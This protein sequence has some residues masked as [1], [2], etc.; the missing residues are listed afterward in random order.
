[1]N[2]PA[3]PSLAFRA[4]DHGDKVTT[5][6]VIPCY[7]S[8]STLKELISSLA[9]QIDAPRFEVVLVDNGPTPGLQELA[10]ANKALLD[11]TLVMATQGTGTAYARNVGIRSASGSNIL[12]VDHDD[13]VE[14]QYVRAMTNALKEH[15]FVCAKLDLKALN[16]P[17]FLNPP[18]DQYQQTEVTRFPGGN[19]VPFASGGT[20]GFRREV[21]VKV[22]PFAE[23]V[24]YCDDI[25]FC[26][27]AHMAGVPLKFVP[28]AVLN[29]RLRKG[30]R[31]TFLQRLNWGRAEVLVFKKYAAT[32]GL[33]AP[34]L[35]EQLLSWRA[36][37]RRAPWI[38]FDW[39]RMWLAT[40]G[41]NRVGRLIGSILYLC[42]FL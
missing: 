16:P 37:F 4:D 21:Y 40:Y 41:G 35:S 11:I 3:V 34:A 36:L 2:T 23:D 33:S 7:L 10:N 30:V 22:G 26:I 18:F 25:D 5:S 28:D 12:L 38:R 27:R 29:Y 14:Q 6:V 9:Q 17:Y 8:L 32:A 13:T 39:G 1:M 31:K 15:Q 20:L 19:P 42:F 24:P